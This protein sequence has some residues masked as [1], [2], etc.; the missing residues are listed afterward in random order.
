[1][2]DFTEEFDKIKDRIMAGDPFSL[3]RFF[4]G[5]WYILAEKFI[6]IRGKANGEWKYDPVDGIDNLHRGLLIESLKYQAQNY[7]IGIMTDCECL[8]LF[9]FGGQQLMTD[10]SEQP[11]TNLTFASVFMYENY[12][13]VM[14]ELI[15][16][17]SHYKTILVVNRTAR[18]NQ[19]P[20]NIVNYYT[21]ST[22]AWI[23]DYDIVIDLKR[24][25]ETRYDR[26]YLFLIC[27]GPLSNMLVH[28]LHKSNPNNTY[29]NFGSALD[30][31]MFGDPTRQYQEDPTLF[32]HKCTWEDN[33]LHI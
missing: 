19:V 2:K 33:G 14:S 8:E 10:I 30:E 13:R 26:G 6:D 17:M 32:K 1:M 5:E 31:Y 25:V 16:A 23:E 24:Q 21:V 9:K 27:T 20:L 28:E 3:T 15:P 29:I 12:R 11:L 22:N 7:Y 18:V 4:D